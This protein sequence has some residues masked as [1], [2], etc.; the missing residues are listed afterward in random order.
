MDLEAKMTHPSQIL[1]DSSEVLT[2]EGDPTQSNWTK[3]LGILADNLKGKWIYRGHNERKL[4]G[5]SKTTLTI[6]S[7]FDREFSN[8]WLEDREKNQWASNTPWN[9]RWAYEANLLREFKRAAHH[10]TTDLPPKNDFLEWLSLGRHFEMPCRLVDFSYSFWVAAYFALSGKSRDRDGYVLS[11]SHDWLDK[12]TELLQKRHPRCQSFDEQNFHNPEHFHWFAFG[13]K[14]AFKE[15]VVPVAPG[16]KNE[17][18]IAQQGLFLCQGDIN[19]TFAEALSHTVKNGVQENTHV[20]RLILLPS[21]WRTFILTELLKTNV[22]GAVLFP[23]LQGFGQSLRD[24]FHMPI[25]NQ[26]SGRFISEL[27]V[28]I[29]DKPWF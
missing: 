11:L 20:M 15:I 27:E 10:F 14:C 12:N 16:R 18:L 26:T 5:T 28:S 1:F 23:D 6:E 21:E 22:K 9:F 3:F 8:L 2:P 29:S 7:S 19:L 25:G 24:N 17:R 4:K 13:K